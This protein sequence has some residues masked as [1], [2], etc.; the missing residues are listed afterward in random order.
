MEDDFEL[1]S[2]SNVDDE[3]GIPGDEAESSLLKVGEEKEIG[4]NGLKKKLIK[5]GEGWETPDTGDEV[6]GKLSID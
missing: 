1:P 5:E 2:A 4:K 3:M 6:E